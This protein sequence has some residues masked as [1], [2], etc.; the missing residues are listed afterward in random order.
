[1]QTGQVAD[2]VVNDP[3]LVLF[4]QEKMID[5]QVLYGRLPVAGA[6]M[7]GQVCLLVCLV[8][9]G[10]RRHVPGSRVAAVL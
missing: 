7:Q 9:A 2:G 5:R 6:C 4:L 1:M 8:L 10:S 3:K